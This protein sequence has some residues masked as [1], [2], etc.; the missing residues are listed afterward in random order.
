[1]SGDMIDVVWKQFYLNS[2]FDFWGK[3]GPAFLFVCLNNDVFVPSR[4]LSWRMGGRREE[5]GG[6]WTRT[7]RR[8]QRNENLWGQR[9]QV[10]AQPN[11]R[12]IHFSSTLTLLSSFVNEMKIVFIFMPI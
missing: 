5:G 12:L 1:M 8:N 9:T 4:D 3:H 2:R 11:V 7:L 10:A 6:R